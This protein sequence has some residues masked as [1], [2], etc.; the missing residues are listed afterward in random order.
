MRDKRSFYGLMLLVLVL[1]Y[2][3]LRPYL[4]IIF[5]AFMTAWAF[6]GVY[7]ILFQRL[8]RR[9]YLAVGVTTT[10]IV[11]TILI[12]FAVFINLIVGQLIVL[13]RELNNFI[14][15]K[16]FSVD[17]LVMVVNSQLSQL[18]YL[19]LQVS[20]HDILL[21]LD[22]IGRP[23]ANFL[24]DKAIRLGGSTPDMIAKSL[25]Y[26][27][28]LVSFL[29]KSDQL[30]KY[31]K[32]LSPLPSKINDLYAT[33]ILAMTSA[34]FKGTLV[35]ALVQALASTLLLWIVGVGY[36]F[37]LFVLMLFLGIIP[38]VGASTVMLPV[39]FYLLLTG[40]TWQGALVLIATS[41]VVSNL[42]NIL[43]PM[44]VPKEAMLSPALVMVGIF[45]G[46]SMFGPLGIVYGPVVMIILMTTLE[47][48]SKYYSGQARQSS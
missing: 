7:Q 33:R 32:S 11:V 23:I 17:G 30:L 31:L 38:V 5:L 10:L 2:L 24:L 28:F 27:I 16:T 26:V 43:R 18:P 36:L 40:S 3:M 47:V 42:D 12:P 41:L 46:I 19:G 25:L 34:M 21:G 14:T 6:Q 39:G 9:S 45:G 4:S 35:V 44:L 8:G 15:G 1:A 13:S 48:Y 29:P 20:R 37:V 22:E